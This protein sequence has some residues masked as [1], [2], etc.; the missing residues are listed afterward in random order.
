MLFFIIVIFF[1]YNITKAYMVMQIIANEIINV[2][3]IYFIHTLSFDFDTL[4]YFFTT[5]IKNS[6][7]NTLHIQSRAK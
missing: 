1:F 5:S 4:N 6:T 7:I 3:Y 2:A